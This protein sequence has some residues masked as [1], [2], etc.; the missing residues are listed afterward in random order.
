MELQLDEDDSLLLT[1]LKSQF[2]KA[3][4]I[5]LKISTFNEEA[6][7][8]ESFLRVSYP[9]SDESMKLPL[10]DDNSLLLTTLKSQF[11]N[12]IGLSYQ[13]FDY[14]QDHGKDVC[15]RPKEGKIS[16]P[17]G[18]WSKTRYCSRDDT[19]DTAETRYCSIP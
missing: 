13:R 11:P 15:A 8:R 14:G 5:L 19:A 2:P 6:P 16:P 4:A 17:P 10:E 3:N 9:N 18:G 12:A 7:L 1:I